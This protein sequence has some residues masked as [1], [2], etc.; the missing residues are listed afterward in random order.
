M[1]LKRLLE[2]PLPDDWDATIYNEMVPF[3]QRLRYAK[4]RAKQVGRGSSR[5]AFAIPYQGRST[6]LKVATNRKG[7]AQ[8]DFESQM[9]D[10]HY[11]KSFDI[12]IPMIDYD[13][14]SSTPT[15]IHTERAEKVTPNKWKQLAHGYPIEDILSFI[16]KL[17]GDKFM[18]FPNI[19]E[20]QFNHM[21]EEI[22]EDSDFLNGLFHLVADFDLP[23]YDFGRLSNWGIY[24]NRLVIVDLG[25]SKEVLRMY[26]H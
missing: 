15:W 1:K 5:V 16:N 3:T 24:Q 8:N 18:I 6:I 7:M 12:M 21:L 14:Q 25:L 17:M 19:S 23:I 20:E 10:D 2:T 9:F 26:Y 22:Y 11:A 4:E 13:E